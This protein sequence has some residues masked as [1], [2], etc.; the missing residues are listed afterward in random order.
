MEANI[1]TKGRDIKQNFMSINLKSLRPEM[2]GNEIR[3]R[4]KGWILEGLEF[5][6]KELV[7]R[8]KGPPEVTQSRKNQDQVV[9]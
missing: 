1:C 5:C 4:G 9:I 7:C 2:V 6:S 8:R 3:E